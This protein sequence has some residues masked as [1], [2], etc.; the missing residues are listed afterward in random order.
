VPFAGVGVDID[1]EEDLV[2][3]ERGAIRASQNR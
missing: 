1:E 3:L 2:W